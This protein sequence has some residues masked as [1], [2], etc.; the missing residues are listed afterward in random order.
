MEGT[1]KEEVRKYTEAFT[2]V[3]GDDYMHGRYFTYW[4]DE[5]LV[6]GGLVSAVFWIDRPLDVVWPHFIDFGS[7]FRFNE[8]QKRRFD[9][10]KKQEETPDTTVN[11]RVIPHY[12]TVI[13]QV[14]GGRMPGLGGAVDPGFM[15][16]AADGFGDRT[17]V[18]MLMEHASLMSRDGDMTEDEALDH[19]GPAG[20]WRELVMY[21]QTNWR[22]LNIPTLKKK[23]YEA[24]PT[25]S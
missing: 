10:W 11:V 8:E 24:D 6:A 4:S 17:L 15:V 23:V 3:D 2:H 22:D 14:G 13:S 16:F 20:S 19:P 25:A 7:W 5:G 21:A 1:A 18:M 9:A 12:M